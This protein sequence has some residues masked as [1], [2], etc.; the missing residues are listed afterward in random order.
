MRMMQQAKHRT[1]PMANAVCSLRNLI[2]L[3]MS[4]TCGLTERN[5]A[6]AS[7]QGHPVRGIQT[8]GLLRCIMI[9][10]KQRLMAE[11]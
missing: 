1:P 11:S 4:A 9:I 8:I 2:R 7:P 6:V 3:M 10:R 5:C